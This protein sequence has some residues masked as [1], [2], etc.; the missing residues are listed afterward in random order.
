[1]LD[2]WIVGLFTWAS[3]GVA[4]GWTNVTT[5]ITGVWDSVVEWFK[6]PK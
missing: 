6:G 3:E 5:F 2:D 1:M 4:K